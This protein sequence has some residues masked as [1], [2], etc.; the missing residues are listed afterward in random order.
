M[1]IDS[2]IYGQLRP[3]RMEDPY[4][5]A[6]K[7]LQLRQA[8][9]QFRLEDDLAAAGQ[10]SGGDPAKMAE[11][12][13]QRGH[14][15][16]ALKIRSQ[17]ET[18][19]KERRLAQNADTE[20][21]LRLAEAVGSDAM[22]LDSTFRQALQQSNGN[23]EAAIQA[24]APAY[25]QIR[26]KWAR[27]GQNLPEQFDPEANFAGIGQAKE[28]VQYL[29]TLQPKPE[30][31][32]A[33][34][35]EYEYAKG[36]GFA[37]T[38]EQFQQQQRKAGATTVQV[39]TGPMLPGKEGANRVDKE[40]LD[41]TGRVMRLN[42]IGVQFK[43]EFQTIATRMSAAWSAIK[44]KAGVGLTNKQRQELTDFASFKREA[45][46]NLNQYINEVT[47][48]AMSEQEVPRI[49]AGVPDPG[50][51][52]FDGDS[53][54]EFKSKFDGTMRAL[55]LAEARLAY[56][57]RNGM[58]LTDERGAPV[59]PLDRMPSIMKKRASEIEAQLRTSN[60]SVSDAELRKG[61]RA[62][63]ARDF[64]LVE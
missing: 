3:I 41:S 61:L 42:E 1:A 18:A 20:R 34:V 54:T 23:R 44:E 53:P 43:P 26:S 32:P 36:Q 35:R 40:L 13:L 5:S 24:V 21:Q 17:L 56:I 60:P 31:K 52:V 29:K 51:G 46:A 57:K 37:G 27:L 55:K 28:S 64:G 25:G 50:T 9:K 2:S 14:H 8:Q 48:A 45:V 22:M 15:E 30:E 4:D 11:I 7:A 39:N 38:F 63:L 59:V 33:S 62:Q 47:G 49:R 58:S 12:L 6:A 19:N 10:E 16:P